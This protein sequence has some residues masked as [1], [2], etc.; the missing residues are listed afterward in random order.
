M[1]LFSLAIAWNWLYDKD[2]VAGIELA[3]SRRGLTTY[4]I[5]P[6]NVHETLARL[7]AGALAFNTFLDRASDDDESFEPLVKFLAK[8]PTH[9]FNQHDRVDHAKDKATM[10]LEFITN[11]LHVPYTIIVSPY[12]KKREI[13]LSL[14]E[15]AKLG[16]PFIIKPANT[17]GGGTGVVLG[18][19]SLKDVIETRQHHKNDKYLLQETVR[20]KFLDGTKA[21]FRVLYGFGQILPCWWDDTTHEYRRVTAD[22]ETRFQIG[23]L[24]DIMKTIEKVCLLDFFSSEIALTDEGKFVVV[25]YVNE[26]CDMRL[27]SKHRDGVPDDVVAKIQELVAKEASKYSGQ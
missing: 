10:H 11:G 21:W 19:E 16:R 26:I 1:E 9:T 15:L 4:R 22:E 12:N 6:E 17:T 5:E 27:Q 23:A 25:D 7:R 18:A 3:C 14:S 24:H 8:S 20:P 2:F 13:E